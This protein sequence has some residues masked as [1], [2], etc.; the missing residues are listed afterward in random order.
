MERSKC[1]TCGK[2]DYEVGKLIEEN[3]E[4]RRLIA[5]REKGCE[6]CTNNSSLPMTGLAHEIYITGNALYYYDSLCGWE[7]IEIECCPMCGRKLKGD[8]HE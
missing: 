1:L 2:P 5:K 7:G 4:L 6:Y 8:M 3:R